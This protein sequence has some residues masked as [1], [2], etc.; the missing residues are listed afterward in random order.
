[1]PNK[2]QKELLSSI[3]FILNVQQKKCKINVLLMT[4]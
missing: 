1:M 4:Y 2:T 3:R